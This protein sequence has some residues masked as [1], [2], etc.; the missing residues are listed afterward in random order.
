MMS[1]LLVF[2]ACITY[3]GEGSEIDLPTPNM[4]ETRE[5]CNLTH[6]KGTDG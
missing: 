4:E 6:S 3:P 5:P 1:A 2:E